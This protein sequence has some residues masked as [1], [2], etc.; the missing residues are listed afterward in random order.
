M[1]SWQIET[2]EETAE[3]EEQAREERRH[4][5]ISLATQRIQDEA[6]R[7]RAKCR[8]WAKEIFIFHELY[9]LSLSGS[10]CFNH[11]LIALIRKADPGNTQK[12][13]EGFPVAVKMIEQWEGGDPWDFYMM[14]EVRELLTGGAAE[15]YDRRLGIE[16]PAVTEAESDGD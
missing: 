9:N 5:E 2:P 1:P 3:R 12:L 7:L 16:R 15:H 14:Y 10:P 8:Y 11:M 4:R 13:R 6:D